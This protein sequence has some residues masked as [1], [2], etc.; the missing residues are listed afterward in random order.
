MLQYAT[1]KHIIITEISLN[2]T[3]INPEKNSKFTWFNVL[4]DCFE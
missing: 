2:V 4:P 3:L 1:D